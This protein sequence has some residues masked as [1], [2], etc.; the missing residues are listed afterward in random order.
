M[1]VLNAVRS[2]AADPPDDSAHG[3]NPLGLDGKSQIVDD[4]NGVRILEATEFVGEFVYPDRCAEQ[5]FR[6]LP[7]TLV[8]RAK[9][10]LPVLSVFAKYFPDLGLDL[11]GK[12]KSVAPIADN[13][14]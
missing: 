6:C 12:R 13:V 4:N 5:L 8:Y 14:L 1:R 3:S 10:L 2:R 7:H 9:S 11:V